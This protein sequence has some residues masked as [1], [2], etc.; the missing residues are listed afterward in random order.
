[1]VLLSSH[2][3][4]FIIWRSPLR[5]LVKL[6]HRSITLLVSLSLL[7]KVKA[8]H[9]F[10]IQAQLTVEMAGVVGTSLARVGEE[11]L[12]GGNVFFDVLRLTGCLFSHYH[13]PPTH[14][15]HSTT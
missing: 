9:V 1:M 3:A 5:R 12:P 15:P 6:A 8:I 7:S 14:T 2:W 10:C 4:E 13:L 11:H